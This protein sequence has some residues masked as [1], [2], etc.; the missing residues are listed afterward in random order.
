MVN[1]TA[2]MTTMDIPL[3][4]I[5]PFESFPL[6]ELDARRKDGEKYDDGRY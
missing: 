3:G 6:P 2:N 4:M 5:T 1:A